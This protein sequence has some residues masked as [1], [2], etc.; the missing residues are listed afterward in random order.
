MQDHRRLNTQGLAELSETNSGWAK[1]YNQWSQRNEQSI[2]RLVK[3]GVEG[4]AALYT[5]DL[6]SSLAEDQLRQLFRAM[7]DSH[8]LGHTMALFAPFEHAVD[9]LGMHL[10]TDNEDEAVHRAAFRAKDR[11]DFVEICLLTWKYRVNI[12]PKLEGKYKGKV[13]DAWREMPTSYQDT[14]FPAGYDVGEVPV[15]YTTH[16]TPNPVKRSFKA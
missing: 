9:F 3:A 10:V 8:E 13:F 14:I 11:H 16:Q 2:M 4:T 1:T 7:F 6:M 15:P 12:N 5:F